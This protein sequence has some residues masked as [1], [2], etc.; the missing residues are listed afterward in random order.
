MRVAKA[1]MQ[2][3]LRDDYEQLKLS[4]DGYAGYDSWFSSSLNNAQLSTV[5][6]YNDL[7]P[8]FDDLLRQSGGDLEQFFDEVDKLARLSEEERETRLQDWL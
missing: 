1:R 8:F 2:Q 7:V 4:W 6:S 5:S 3:Q